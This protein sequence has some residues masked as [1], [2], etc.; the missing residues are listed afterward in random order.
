MHI[1]FIISGTATRKNLWNGH[2][3]RYG[4]VGVSGTDQS[5]VLFAEKL[6]SRGH[7]VH[8]ISETCKRGTEYK[9]VTYSNAYPENTQLYDAI[10][11]T[12]NL[13]IPPSVTFPNAKTL[14]IYCQ[15]N[16][17][18]DANQLDAFIQR[19]PSCKIRAVHVSEWGK[20]STIQSFP[21]YRKY[22]DKDVVIYNPLM[23]DVL[24]SVPIQKQPK[25][26]I[27]H[28]VW[29]RGGDVAQ[30]VFDRLGWTREGGKMMAL[31]Y[32]T[33]SKIATSE[34]KKI[35][36][37][38]SEIARMLSNADYFIYPLVNSNN[39]WRD[40]VHKDTFGCCVSEALA[41]GAIVITWQVG[42]LPEL[43]NGYAQFAE[44]PTGAN[45]NSL[46]GTGVSVDA[47]LRSNEAVENIIKII[48]HLESNPS[49]KDQIR[50]DGMD[51]ARNKFNADTLCPLWDQVLM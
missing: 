18:P 46:T 24:E 28:A 50:K 14:S 37:D 5:A 42:A 51:Y 34:D 39:R 47:S 4:G 27:F 19:H 48:R 29:E 9:G 21:H 43:Y 35:S 49:L 6:A 32:D 7:T 30:E 41:M 26:F 17:I 3:I 31:D 38:K 12:C 44:F 22:I 10:V 13:P 36:G 40:V 33:S 23:M 15:C 20:E 45:V 16:A 8:Y 1:L 25:T 2:I 11:T